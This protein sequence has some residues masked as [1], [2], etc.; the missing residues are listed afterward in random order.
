MCMY[1]Y[2]YCIP[3]PA[4]DSTFSANPGKE[5]VRNTAI[6]EAAIAAPSPARLSVM[7]FGRGPSTF[8]NCW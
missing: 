2:M 8:S 1:V 5:N 6:A 7:L 3:I 4:A